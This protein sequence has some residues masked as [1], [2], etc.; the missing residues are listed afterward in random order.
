MPVVCDDFIWRYGESLSCASFIYPSISGRNHGT[1]P[2]YPPSFGLH[3]AYRVHTDYL[4]GISFFF[5]I[6][7][8]G[9]SGS[10]SRALARRDDSHFHDVC[11]RES[12]NERLC[13][14]HITTFGSRNGHIYQ[15]FTPRRR[16]SWYFALFVDDGWLPPSSLHLEGQIVPSSSYAIFEGLRAEN[17]SW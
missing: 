11:G 13:M 7:H 8:C 2:T 4:L 1:S 5:V 9:R 12:I 3:I 6:A 16:I 10:C 15:Y 14:L 17:K